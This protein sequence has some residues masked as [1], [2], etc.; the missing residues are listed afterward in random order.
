MSFYRAALCFAL[1][2][3]AL[4]AVQ[5]QVDHRNDGHAGTP[6]CTESEVW[7]INK[8]MQK[9]G[10]NTMDVL[11]NI[12]HSTHRAEANEHSNAT[13]AKHPQQIPVPVESF[14]KLM[15]DMQSLV[16]VKTKILCSTP[17]LVSVLGSYHTANVEKCLQSMFDMSEKCAAAIVYLFEDV[18][19][20]SVVDTATSC[21]AA[22]QN[23]MVKKKLD[24]C[25]KCMP[26]KITYHLDAIV[27]PGAGVLTG[28]MISGKLASLPARRQQRKNA[29]LQAKH[30]QHAMMKAM[31]NGAFPDATSIFTASV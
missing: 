20:D 4:D 7:A 16:S 24:K 17:Y 22:C 28:E 3:F 5:M 15:L 2:I 19:G 21:L 27:G 31:E 10:T 25:L 29:E 23:Y 8:G 18:A 13:H 11:L 6:K 30:F 12:G 9:F 1:S 26:N 14:V